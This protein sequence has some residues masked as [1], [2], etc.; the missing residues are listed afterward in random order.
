[1]LA[2]VNEKRDGG[3]RFRAE[4]RGY[5]VTRRTH[6]VPSALSEGLTMH[7]KRTLELAGSIP[8]EDP[9]CESTTIWQS[10]QPHA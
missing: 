6:D 8:F 1:M 10:G 3:G 5:I 9:R 4:A 7:Y 2:V